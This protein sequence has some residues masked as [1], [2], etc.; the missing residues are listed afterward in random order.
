MTEL[1]IRNIFKTWL[2]GKTKVS[3]KAEKER[4]RKEDRARYEMEGGHL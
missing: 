3:R 1:L 4:E 2:I